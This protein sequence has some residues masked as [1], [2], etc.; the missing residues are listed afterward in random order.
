MK[1]GWSLDILDMSW[2]ECTNEETDFVI[3]ALGLHGDERILDLACGFGRHTLELARRGYSV[4]G[5]DFT[6]AYIEHAR[7][8]AQEEQ[9]DS[10]EFLLADVLEVSFHEEFDVVLNMADG[11]IG[12]LGTDS[13]S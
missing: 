2:V 3:Q 7:S 9:L 8:V 13:T 10:A 1:T 12:Y 6:E 5:V 11:A 4:V